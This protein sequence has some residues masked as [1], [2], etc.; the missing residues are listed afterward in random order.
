MT[1]GLPQAP[2]SG[3]MLKW[4]GLESRS[5]SRS[6]HHGGVVHYLA[7]HGESRVAR[8][9]IISAVRPL[10]VKTAANPGGLPRT[11]STDAKPSQGVIWNW[12][13]H[14]DGRQ[15]DRRQP[16]LVRSRLQ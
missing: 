14:G 2:M 1:R 16:E 7:R 12:W 4:E 9:V 11:C 6:A 10:M 5:I 13:R 3:I 8:A 15:D